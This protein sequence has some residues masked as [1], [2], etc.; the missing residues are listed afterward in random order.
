MKLFLK[1]SNGGIK[2]TIKKEEKKITKLSEYM[3][4][5]EGLSDSY[6]FSRGQPGDYSL[7]PSA[8]RKDSKGNRKYTRQ[9]IAHFLNQFKI[10]SQHYMETPWEINNVYEWMIYAQHYGIPTR[11]LDFTQ[12]HIISLMFAVEKAFIDDGEEDVYVW[13][14]DPK[15]LNRLHSQRSEIFVLST[16]SEQELKLDDHNGP[17][18]VQGRKLNMR[19]NAQNGVFLYFQDTDQPLEEILH[20]DILRK[21][22][23]CGKSKKNILVSLYS[24][25]ISFTHIYPELSSVSKD[26]LMKDNISQHAKYIQEE[27]EI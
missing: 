18:A 7:L 22:T 5:V 26:I 21:M 2:L 10:N 1:V 19:I 16:E 15:E 20:E 9:S 12:S 25:G 14:L 11:L 17:V 24:M 23:I 4:Y 13:F 8:L 3:T 6:S 27:E